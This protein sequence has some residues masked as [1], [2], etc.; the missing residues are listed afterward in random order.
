MIMTNRDTYIAGM[1]LQL[2]ELNASM[3]EFECKVHEEREDA[4]DIYAAAVNRLH[5]RSKLAYDTFDQLKTSSEES[6][7]NMVADTEKMRDALSHSF[8]Q[9]KSQSNPGR[10]SWPASFTHT[11]QE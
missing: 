7:K 4:R 5:L 1:K 6:W 3:H 10:P 8:H 11:F 9:F 2:D